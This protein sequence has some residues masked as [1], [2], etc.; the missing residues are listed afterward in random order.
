MGTVAT[1]KSNIESRCAS[2]L[3]GF[4]KLPYTIDPSKNTFK[5]NAAGFAVNPLSID[6]VSNNVRMVA[7]NHTME[8]V[9]TDSF[10]NTAMSDANQA[11][12][13]VSLQEKTYS[14]YVDL[15]STRI[16]SDPNALNITN[17]SV[18]SPE[19]LDNSVILKSTFQ[20]LYR[21]TF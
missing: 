4:T 14:L 17:L 3:T 15:I 6:Q 2:V 13:V 7:S 21:T 9:L 10:I 19:F 18:N 8:L 16:G 11:A 1:L 5:G 20:V 12:T